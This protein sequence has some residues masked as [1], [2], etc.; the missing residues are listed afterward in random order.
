MKTWWK[1]FEKT[2]NVQFFK[3][4][5]VDGHQDVKDKYNISDPPTVI[6]FRNC[7]ELERID[8][9]EESDPN[10]PDTSKPGVES[11][12]EKRLKQKIIELHEKK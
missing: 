6:F 1:T 2:Y 10:V 3:Y 12:D 8:N 5:V 11:N 7:T 9:F 4:T